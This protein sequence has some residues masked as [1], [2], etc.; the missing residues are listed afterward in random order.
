MAALEQVEVRT[1]AFTFTG[2]AAGPEGGPLVV[3][4]HGFPQTSYSWRAQLAVLGDAGF[5]AVAPDQRG[6]SP[7]AR[8]AAVEDYRSTELVADVLVIADSLGAAELH[9]AGHDWGAAI[10]WQVAGRHPERVRTLTAVSVPHPAAFTKAIA[11]DPDQRARSGYMLA[12]RE[13]GAPEDALLA[14]DAAGLRAVYAG[15]E[16][17]AV[18]EYL[19]VLRQPGAL[20]AALNWY[21]AADA[22][23]ATGLG[24]ITTPTLYVWSTADPALGRTAADATAEH[25][26]GPYRFEVLEGVSH[27][28]P[29]E[30]PDVLNRLLLDHIGSLA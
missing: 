14:G 29:E 16:D 15:L 3:L 20:T 1:P 26:A 7:G 2:R 27:W 4:L 28:V 8:P 22:S 18:E 30:A 19:R 23:L 5:R 21:R 13:E 17:D 11:E 10:A 6:Y 24:P 9:L 25:V 12:F